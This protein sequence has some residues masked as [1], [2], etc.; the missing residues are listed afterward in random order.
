MILKKIISVCL[1]LLGICVWV[2]PVALAGQH[3]ILYVD[4]YHQSYPWSAGI[5]RGIQSVLEKHPEIELKIERMDSKRISGEEDIKS[6]ALKV[7]GII[8]SWQPDIVIASDDN[9][10]KYLIVPYFMGAD[11]PFVFCGVNWDASSYGF[12]TANITGMVEVQLIDQIIA[13]LQDYASGSRIAF[14]KGDDLSARIEADFFEKRFDIQLDRRFVSDFSTWKEQYLVLQKEA[15]MILLGNSVSIKGWNPEEAQAFI[16]EAT[17]VPT[18]NWDAWM[19]PYSLVTLANM[20]EEQGEWAA[21]TAL[22]ILSGT[23]PSDIPIAT[24]E[25]AK[26]YLNMEL[27]K[28]IGVKFPIELI[29]RATFTSEL[30]KQ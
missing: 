11:L 6:A 4:S 18:G 17:V 9:A 1:F 19:A 14:I 15:D 7:K 26:I 28:K 5:T 27:A 30:E 10:S 25:K 21:T 23:P 8:D 29:E 2:V 13:I 16:M 22:R 24:N 20:P 3:R 12:P